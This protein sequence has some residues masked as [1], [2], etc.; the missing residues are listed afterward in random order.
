V[1]DVEAD[2]RADADAA[3]AV[4]DLPAAAADAASPARSE[5]DPFA[6]D[7][8]PPATS[9]PDPFAVDELPSGTPQP[10][11]FGADDPPS[12][13]ASTRTGPTPP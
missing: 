13:G 3:T 7:E 1:Q 8:L 9:E 4:Q 11:L 2:V 5:P 6:V 10:D 12:P